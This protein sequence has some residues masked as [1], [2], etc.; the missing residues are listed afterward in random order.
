MNLQYFSGTVYGFKVIGRPSVGMY[1]LMRLLLPIPVALWD[2][3]L[4]YLMLSSSFNLS[5]ATS[6][7]AASRIDLDELLVSAVSVNCRLVLSGNLGS[8]LAVLS[9][10]LVQ[11]TF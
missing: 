9:C 6:G 1:N 8:N 5:L 2:T 11:L 3:M 7:M 4:M 10:S